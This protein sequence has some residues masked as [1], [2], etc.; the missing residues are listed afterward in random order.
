MDN[1]ILYLRLTFP[2]RYSL[3]RD[4]YNKSKNLTYITW[5]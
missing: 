3:N 1:D 2:I 4:N 5:I